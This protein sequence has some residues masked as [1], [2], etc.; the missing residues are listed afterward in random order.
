MK[1]L[2]LKIN[3]HPQSIKNCCKPRVWE[4][5]ICFASP[6]LRYYIIIIDPLMHSF[7]RKHQDQTISMLEA[8]GNE[9]SN[10]IS[11]RM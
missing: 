4:T 10:Y 5:N 7:Y 11:N 9:S 2:N 3:L 8:A 6:Y 1:K